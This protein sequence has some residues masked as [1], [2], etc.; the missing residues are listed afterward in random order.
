MGGRKCTY[1]Y[2]KVLIADI[3]QGDL[4]K[5]ELVTNTCGIGSWGLLNSESH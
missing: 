5:T 3:H 2:E 4:K 1:I